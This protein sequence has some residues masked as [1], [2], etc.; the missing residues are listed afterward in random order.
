MWIIMLKN[1]FFWISQGKVATYDR[2]GGQIS[3]VHVKFS[4]DLAYQI[5]LGSVNFWQSY[6]KKQ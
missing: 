4:R 3:K 1:D 2:W 5:L 6:L